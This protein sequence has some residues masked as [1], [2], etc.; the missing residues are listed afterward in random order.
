MGVNVKKLS[1][2]FLLVFLCGCGEEKAFMTPTENTIVVDIGVPNYSLNGVPLGET[3]K[4][5]REENL[6]IRP[7]DSQLKKVRH[8]NLSANLHISEEYLF[9][10]FFKVLSTLE[11]SGI[12]NIQ[13]VFGS[14]FKSPVQ[15]DMSMGK[16][17]PCLKANR[18]F[19]HKNL[20]LN[21]N[22]NLSHEQKLQRD[23]EDKKTELECAENYMRLHVSVEYAEK[24]KTIIVSLNELGIIRGF[25]SYR[26]STEGELIDSLKSFRERPSLQ[27]KLDKDV[28]LY[29]GKEGSLLQDNASVVHALSLAGYKVK[30]AIGTV[31]H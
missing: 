27:N 9:D 20:G 18:R 25:H 23:L 17:D 8:K 13:I 15:V 24:K 26:L 11:F 4:D 12:K 5:F 1:V 31:S 7:L 16:E 2:L 10:D 29:V 6:L 22:K 3:I 28:A 14:S 21:S 19:L 30:F